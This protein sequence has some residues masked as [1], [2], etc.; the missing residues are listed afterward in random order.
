MNRNVNQWRDDEARAQQQ[1]AF[2]SNCGQCG[3]DVCQRRLILG[4][5]QGDF[6]FKRIGA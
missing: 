5:L 6:E 3:E 2:V 1:P 4:E